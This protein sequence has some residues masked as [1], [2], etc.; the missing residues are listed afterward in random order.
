VENEILDLLRFI[1]Y[2]FQFSTEKIIKGIGK[3]VANLGKLNKQ[4]KKQGLMV[5]I[6]C[7]VL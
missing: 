7:Q 1:V 2:N 5:T 6:C 4:A 3:S